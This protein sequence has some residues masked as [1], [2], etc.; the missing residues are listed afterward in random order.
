MTRFA[1]GLALAGV[2]LTA[3]RPASEATPQIHV[4]PGAAGIWSKVMGASVDAGPALASARAHPLHEGEELGGPNAI[5]RPGDWVLENGEVVFVIDRLGASA[6][7][8]ETGGNLVDAAD[9]RV[10][11]DELGQMFTYFGV[12]PRQ[13]LYDK[14][15]TGSATDGSAWVDVSGRELYEPD[16][17]VATRYTLRAGDRALLLETTVTNAGA[18]ALTL[19]SLGDAIQWGGAEKFA[20]G[21]ATGFK[22][23]SSGPYLGGVG[24]FTSYAMTSTDGTIDGTSGGSWTDT[25][26]RK[27]VTL[28]PGEK[29]AYARVFLVGERPDSSSV[30]AELMKAAGQGVGAV[31]LDLQATGPGPIAIPADARVAVRDPRAGTAGTEGSELLTIHAAGTPPALAAELPPGHWELVYTGGGG[32]AGAEPVAVDVAAGAEAHAKL[33]VTEGASA[34]VHCETD[35]GAPMPCKVTFERTDGGPAPSFGPASAAGPAKNQVTSADGEIDVSLAPG[36]YR[37]TAS[38]GPEYA[39][40]QAPLVLAPAGRGELRL[41]PRRVVDTGGYLGCDFHQHTMLGTDA[42]VGTRDR[43]IANAAEGVEIA[44]ASEHNVI[45][46]LEPIVRALHLER[47]MVSISGDELTSDA[48][49]HAWGHGNAWPLAL[50]P[51]DPRGGAPAVR[52]VPPRDLV[53]ALRRAQPEDF[54]FQINHPRSGSNG[55]FDLYGFD[56]KTGLGADPDYEPGFDALEVWSGRNV[57]ARA[58]VLEDYLALLRTGHPV[59]ATADTDTHGIVGQEAGYPRTYVRV[60]NDAQ[61][62]AWDASRSADLVRGVKGLRDVVLTNG[63]MLRVTASGAPIGGVVRGRTVDVR[64]HVESAP[65]VLVDRVEILR[66]VAS[67]PASDAK[68]VTE[69]PLPDGAIGADVAFTL[70]ASGD[71]VFVVVASGH[72]PMT[73]VL[74]SGRASGDDADALLPWAMTGAIWIDADG[75][76]E[77]LGR[78]AVPAPPR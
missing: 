73:P 1:S 17:H 58:N 18:A 67:K 12:F 61:L 11:K 7:F 14:L 15:A 38:R 10:R 4:I 33:A 62:D 56:R 68:S 19:P 77:A 44:V 65:W 31:V 2:L 43:V 24:R 40:A 25:A 52:D 54:V 72:T 26:L 28:Q 78:H 9:A 37:V 30:V 23:P 53:A 13:A 55:Y 20:P 32:R 34:L 3:C 75:N 48:S 63:P 66:A 74:G 60:A 8:A 45:A 36:E 69:R 21:K 5:G 29:V 16:L 51:A 76:G 27:A 64:V 22:G 39:L 57:A 46:D 49:R 59:T 70:H 71:D 41:A 50:D 6:G 35:A 42:P 47:D